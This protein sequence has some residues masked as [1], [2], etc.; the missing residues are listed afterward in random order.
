MGHGGA[1]TCLVLDRAD[2]TLADPAE[3]PDILA[4]A[5]ELGEHV[6]VEGFQ[7][8]GVVVVGRDPA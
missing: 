3:F 8:D 6:R 7:K 2:G 5:V 4:R 1:N